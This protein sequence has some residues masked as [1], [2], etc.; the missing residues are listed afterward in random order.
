[1]NLNYNPIILQLFDKYRENIF[2]KR[3]PI[4]NVKTWQYRV[5]LQQYFVILFFAKFKDAKTNKRTIILLSY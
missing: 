5:D 1:M 2:L 3:N 4:P